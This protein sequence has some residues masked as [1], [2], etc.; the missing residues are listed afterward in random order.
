MINLDHEETLGLLLA[1]VHFRVHLG[2]LVG[3]GGF[4][5]PNLEKIMRSNC[6]GSI[7]VQDGSNYK[8]SMKVKEGSWSK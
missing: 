5:G 6:R 8:G 4:P 1:R 2:V 7:K 3:P